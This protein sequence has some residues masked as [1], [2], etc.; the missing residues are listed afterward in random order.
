LEKGRGPFSPCRPRFAPTLGRSHV[1]SQP[2]PVPTPQPLTVET[3]T[4]ALSLPPIHLLCSARMAM[5]VELL[6][7]SRPP[8]TAFAPWSYHI[9]PSCHV[10]SRRRCRCS[11]YHRCCASRGCRARSS[12]M[13][14]SSNPL[15]WPSCSYQKHARHAIV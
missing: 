5:P 4:L 1:R 15:H 10:T 6:P 8:V 3:R 7:P 14:P 11:L 13:R 12:T 2:N 9:V